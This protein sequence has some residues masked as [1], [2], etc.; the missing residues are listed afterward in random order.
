M[1]SDNITKSKYTPN[2][3]NLYPRKFG[4]LTVIGYAGRKQRASG[5]YRHFWLCRCDC[6]QFKVIVHD[7]L[8]YR[9]NPSCG[10][11]GSRKRIGKRTTKH[12]LRQSPEY[13]VWCTIKARCYN[14]HAEKY[15]DYGAR[16]IKVSDKWR[17]SFA[18]FYRD[19]GPRP[20]PDYS[21]ERKDNNGNYEKDN[22]KWA[23]RLEQGANKRN[24]RI[25]EFRG[26]SLH[27]AEWARRLN[28][29][30][31]LIRDRLG[32]GWSVER[33]LTAPVQVHC[34]SKSKRT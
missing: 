22:C 4:M 34:R 5:A 31:D 7:T 28:V 27:L 10:C 16:G 6:K 15:P 14:A 18:S 11:R 3:E 23:T 25:L 2:C 9:E 29:S 13:G 1:Q 26:E 8:K 12:G 32:R 19:M 24:N 21:I 30:D 20:G 17:A 33:A